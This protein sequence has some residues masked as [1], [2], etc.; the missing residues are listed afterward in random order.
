MSSADSV[1]SLLIT[2]N[3]VELRRGLHLRRI[4]AR[5]TVSV[6]AQVTAVTARGHQL[7]GCLGMIILALL[8]QHQF[9]IE[10]DQKLRAT[11]ARVQLLAA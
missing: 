7:A 8:Q 11:R 6:F 5:T 2:T 10:F 3:L 4:Q 1:S 9:C